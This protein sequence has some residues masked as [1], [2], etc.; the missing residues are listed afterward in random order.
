MSSAAGDGGTKREQTLFAEHN[1]FFDDLDRLLS[2]DSNA[3]MESNTTYGHPILDRLAGILD[4]YQEQS[5]L[6]D[7]YMERMVTKTT[8]ELKK[9]LK[10]E[11]GKEYQRRS[12]EKGSSHNV[13]SFPFQVFT[14]QRIHLWCKFLYLLCKTR[15]YKAVIKYFPHE[16]SDFEPVAYGLLCQDKTCNETWSTRYTLLLW[17]SMLVLIPFDLQTVDSG[18]VRTAEPQSNNVDPSIIDTIISTCKEYLADASAVRDAAAICLSRLLARPDMDYNYLQSYL[19]WAAQQLD[20]HIT[21]AKPQS[22]F[23]CTGILTSLVEIAKHG[24]REVL[25]T[26]FAETFDKVLSTVNASLSGGDTLSETGTRSLKASTSMRKLIVKLACRTGLTFLPPRVVKWRY[27]R[28]QRSLLQNLRKTEAG[29]NSGDT[30]QTESIKDGTEEDDDDDIDIPS[31]MEEIIEILLTGLRDTDTVVRWSAAKGVGRITIRLPRSFGDEVVEA[32]MQLLSPAESDASWHG[33]CLA[34]AELS[35]RG[36]LLPSR[37]PEAVPLIAQALK[38]DVRKGSHSIGTHVRD[39]ACYVC[40]AFARAYEPRLMKPYVEGLANAMLQVALYDREVNCRRAAAAAF[41]ENVG[42]QGNE[43][44]PHGIEVITAADYFTLGNRAHAYTAVAH[45]VA[46]FSL[47]RYKLIEELMNVKLFHWDH[48][49]RLLSARG[50]AKIVP[51]DPH[52]F[53]EEVLPIL[54]PKVRSADLLERHGAILAVGECILALSQIP[55]MLSPETQTAIRNIIP[56]AEKAR[57]YRGRGGQMVRS[58]A[59]RL[60]ECIALAQLPMSHRATLRLLQTVEECLRHPHE[61]VQSIANS[62]FRALT[63]AYLTCPDESVLD[64]L[65]HSN[66]K[67]LRTD[68][69]P[70]VRRGSAIA[71]GSLPHELL[72]SSK[73]PHIKDVVL[74]TLLESSCAQGD[75][76]FR[77]AETRCNAV[78]ALADVVENC[79]VQVGD[80]GYL[81]S[82]DI[83]KI[84]RTLLTAAQDYATDSRGDVGSWVRKATVAC[85]T[86]LIEMCLLAPI[87]AKLKL[88]TRVEFIHNSGESAARE[89]EIRNAKGMTS[90]DVWDSSQQRHAL[91]MSGGDARLEDAWLSVQEAAYFASPSDDQD[92]ICKAVSASPSLR[93]GVEVDSPWGRGVVT[94]VLAAGNVCDVLFERPALG[95]FFFYLGSGRINRNKLQPVS[96][97][98]SY[99]LDLTTATATQEFLPKELCMNLLCELLRL[100]G[101]K[102]DSVRARAGEALARLLH[103]IGVP[104]SL[105]DV[106]YMPEL[107]KA[108]PASGALRR[109]VKREQGLFD[110]RLLSYFENKVSNM[111]DDSE[112]INYSLGNQTFP[113]L[114]PLLSIPEYT[115]SIVE[116]LVLSVG[117]LSESVVKNSSDA[118]QKW[119]SQ[120]VRRKDIDSLRRVANSLLI[121][122]RGKELKRDVTERSVEADKDPSQ[123]VFRGMNSLGKDYKVQSRVVTPTLRM[124][125]LLISNGFLDALQPPSE[126]F[127]LDL[128]P[129]VRYR[130]MKSK[131]AVRVMEA[132]NVFLGLLS[133]ASP[134]LD[135]S[136]LATLDLMGHP[137]PKIRKVTAEKLYVRIMTLVDLPIFQGEQGQQNHESLV[138]I[139]TETQW[140]GDLSNVILARDKCYPLFCLETPEKRMGAVAEDGTMYGGFL[141]QSAKMGGGNEDESYKALV[142]EAGY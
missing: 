123:S 26:P 104:L 3:T 35:R 139:L 21:D 81:S 36:L 61:D 2:L 107:Q 113:R 126:R 124:L 96:A 111:S 39:A 41:Q 28:G 7:S 122:L 75:T 15:K 115:E 32:V 97:P 84:A 14:D 117:G 85:I 34:L 116:G 121:M 131:D 136:L 13:P 47:Y 64:R 60:I 22:V 118:V 67:S 1:E 134:A 105:P 24:H 29:Y 30:L 137:F 45:E 76:T 50:L 62:A 23:A 6:L 4:K 71:L 135:S 46:K 44:F 40:W 17:M 16:V 89:Q 77:D 12:D 18:L 130:T 114:V 82:Q 27:Q 80:Y 106:P 129:L 112:D 86:R 132:A 125:N 20:K 138:Q 56:R 8:T 63:R 110:A 49:I 70:A 25:L 37:L 65:V 133:F 90:E 94:G 66:C 140:D 95:F 99:S 128:I 102:L 74:D 98:D 120:R 43:N 59:C 79:G 33:G 58:A 103:G 101:E 11:Q 92:T 119:A 51:L 48:E 69:N 19:H 91:S 57:V 142:K 78:S 68:E 53:S 72:D 38:Y 100:Q 10:A 9:L 83:E 87:R 55:F 52:F 73:C 88:P 93:A 31:E 109:R 5:Q 42:R 127:T 141:E 108:F 54:I